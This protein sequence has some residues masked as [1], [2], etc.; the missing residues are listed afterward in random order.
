[1]TLKTVLLGSTLGGAY[2]GLQNA[3][4][5]EYDHFNDW[6]LGSFDI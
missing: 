3:K 4:C 1:V 5:I 2:W 6:T